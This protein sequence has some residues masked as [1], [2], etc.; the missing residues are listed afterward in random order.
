VTPATYKQYND[1]ELI[2]FC[3]QGDS[4]AWEALIM[5]YK[6]LIYSIPVRFN[7]S[8]PDA[9]DVF[10]STC[11]LLIEHLHELRNEQRLVAWLTTT[12][13]RQCF[14]MRAQRMRDTGSEEDEVDEAL[15]PDDNLDDMRLQMER[16]QTVRE[17]IE[18]L[19]DRC[20]ELIELLYFDSRA[21]SYEE[22][23]QILSMPIPSIGPNRARCFEK[24]R[25]IL[26]R[27]GVR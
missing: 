27:R 26:R 11:L 17:S 1:T 24:L 12:A 4:Q 9:A 19:P 7:F 20:R 3:L 5:R 13:S 8:P 18:L 21:P 22:I 15:Q 16:E 25:A 14:R 6:R 2:S 10:Q 23:A